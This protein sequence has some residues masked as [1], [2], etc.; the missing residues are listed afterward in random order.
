LRSRIGVTRNTQSAF[1][2]KLA[3]AGFAAERLARNMEHNAARMTFR[4]TGDPES[5]IGNRPDLAT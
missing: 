2:Q 5:E 1:M 4:A 3:S